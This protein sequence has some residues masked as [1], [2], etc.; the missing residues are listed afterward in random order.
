MFSLALRLAALTFGLPQTV[1]AD[2]L[3][4]VVGAF[5]LLSDYSL[6]HNTFLYIPPLFA[7]I[8]AP[9][10][11]LF[12]VLGI[13]GGYFQDILA[14]KNY[15]LLHREEF[16]IAARFISALFG[17]ATVYAAYRLGEYGISRRVGLLGA[18]FLSIS[19]LHVHETQVGRFWGLA[20]FFVVMGAYAIL[21][22]YREGSRRWYFL[23]ALLIGLGFG[24]GYVPLVLVPW[25]VAAHIVRLRAS[26]GAVEEQRREERRTFGYAFVLMSSLIGLFSW[27]NMYAFRRQ[28][29]WLVGSFLNIFGTS[30]TNLTPK[31]INLS[32]FEN[33]RDITAFL[34]SENAFLV[35]AGFI[36]FAGFA[37]ISEKSKRFEY[38]LFA[39]VPIVYL[40]GMTFGFSVIEHR[41][42]LP[43]LP[44]ILLGASYLFFYAWEYGVTGRGALVLAYALGVIWYSVMPTS[45]YVRLLQ[46]P[47]TRIQAFEWVFSNLPHESTVALDVRNTFLPVTKESIRFTEAVSPFWLNTRDR[48]LLT[49]PDAEYPRPAYHVFDRNHLPADTLRL[50]EI[51]HGYYIL[52]FW[53]SQDRTRMLALPRD[54]RLAA[55]FYPA[56]SG[57]SL[58]DIFQDPLRPTDT[59]RAIEFSGPFIEIYEFGKSK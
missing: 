13:L 50:E 12:G 42:I 46:K 37:R 43:A 57:A 17:T 5:R 1:F 51:S 14:F 41:F 24:M 7:Y 47:D 3:V 44:F 23:S 10:F 8:L 40:L 20:T 55:K 18:L 31:P 30:L 52:G 21:R 4:S 27:A 26:G 49:L 45:M 48:L 9:V 39:G 19:F 16:L 33:V 22:M 54:A 34:G 36:G 11:A 35:L 2:E 59:L 32:I 25:F 6:V 56:E 29:G 15:V 53:D 38:S 58:R 28:F